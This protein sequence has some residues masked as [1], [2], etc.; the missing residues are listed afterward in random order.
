MVKHVNIVTEV[1][2]KVI[3]V[4]MNSAD[5]KIHLLHRRLGHPSFATM[6]N[7][8]PDLF[9]RISL[10]TVFCEACQLAQLKHNTYVLPNNRCTSPFQLI[11]CDIL[12]SSPHIDMNSFK[13]F[14]ICIDDHSRFCWLFLH[15]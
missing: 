1:E 2:A 13:W 9:G 12:G 6:K 7:M 3:V 15:R 14:L 8:Y 5:E 11:H 4:S 10:N